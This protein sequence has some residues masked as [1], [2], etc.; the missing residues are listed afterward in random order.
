MA[1]TGLGAVPAAVFKGTAQVASD[2]IFAG[3]QQDMNESLSLYLKKR[4]PQL[5]EIAG[6]N[7]EKLQNENAASLKAKLDEQGIVFAE[8]NNMVGDDP[9]ARE[10]AQGMV[11]HAIRSTSKATLDLISEHDGRLVNA[12]IRV[13]TITKA[14]M[15]FETQTVNVLKNHE[16]ALISLKIDMETM[17]EAVSSIDGR[18]RTQERN[19]G[20]VSDF[21][22]DSMPAGAKAVALKSGFLAERFACPPEDPACGGPELKADLIKRF[23][24]EARIAEKVETVRLTVSAMNDVASIAGN[25]GLNVPGLNEAVQYGS[26]AANAFTAFASGNYL[27]A[28]ASI[29]G[30]FRRQVDP[31]AERFK[32]LMGYLQEQFKEINTKLAQIIENQR[33]MMQAI[34]KLSEQMRTY[35]VA[36]DERLVRMEF[37]LKR[38]GDAARSGLWDKWTPCLALYEHVVQHDS[39]YGYLAKG[40]FA[41][42]DDLYSAIGTIGQ[43]ALDCA[44]IGQTRPISIAGSD[45]FG[46]FLDARLAYNFTPDPLPPAEAAKGEILQRSDLDTFINTVHAPSHTIVTDFLVREGLPLSRGFELMIS[47]TYTLSHV[48]ERLK[49]KPTGSPCGPTG[50]L[51]ERVKRLLCG[52]GDP[53]DNAAK[54]LETPMSVDAAIVITEW[55]LTVSRFADLIDQ[56]TGKFVEQGDL[57][58]HAAETVSSLSAG[59][60]ILEKTQAMLDAAVSGYSVLY[61]DLTAKSIADALYSPLPADEAQRARKKQLASAAGLLLKKNPFLAQ[62]VA[63]IRLHDRL[64]ERNG[65]TSAGRPSSIQYRVAYE[66]ALRSSVD[67]GFLLRGIFGDDLTFSVDHAKNKVMI[68]L[69]EGHSDAEVVLAPLAEPQAFVEGRLVYPNRLTTLFSARQ[70]VAERLS[71]Y[72]AMATLDAEEREA[73]AL[74]LVRAEQLAPDKRP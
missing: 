25:L 55:L 73:V 72:Q 31:D 71:D 19:A 74:A 68:N 12:E 36:L 63:L 57:L 61:G 4:E 32:I 14:L 35:Y 7:Y 6:G 51:Q 10:R 17:Q 22:F 15:K 33:Q 45:W 9:I 67:P 69:T 16:N 13:G 44:K 1:A 66:S 52:G 53:N 30:I 47:P 2:A 50:Y 40:D 39:K 54:L 11:I 3:M 21:V 49:Q 43:V 46:N 28:I 41:R 37:E 8:I 24:A 58:K 70:R 59:R 65:L 42:I 38:V 20:F 27:G 5:L 48:S 23:E 56:Q 29:T 62:N 18:L 60:D 34:G 26:V 64:R